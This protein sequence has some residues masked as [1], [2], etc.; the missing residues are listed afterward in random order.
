MT[1]L[2][3]LAHKALVLNPPDTQRVFDAIPTAKPVPYNGHTLVAVPYRLDETRVLRNMGLQIPSPIGYLYDWPHDPVAI[4]EVMP[5][6]KETSA[7]LTLHPR[8]YCLNSIGCG[9]TI[10]TG[11]AADFLLR[12]GVH[13]KILVVAPLSTLNDAWANAIFFHFGHLKCNVL[14][15]TA[16]KRRKL[17]L[18][19]ADIYVINFD[20]LETIVNKKVN[21]KGRVVDASLIRDDIGLVVLDEGSFLRNSNT[22]RYKVV[23]HILKPHMWCWDLTATPTPQWPTDAWAQCKLVTPHTVPDHFTSFKSKTMKQITQYKWEPLPNAMDIVYEAMRPAIRFTRDQVFADLEEP[24]YEQRS[25]ELTT[26]QKKHYQELMNELSTELATGGQVLAANEGVKIL[27]LIQAACGVMYD[28]QGQTHEVDCAPRI[29][30]VKEIIEQC[31]EKVIVFAPLEGVV[32]MLHREISKME[33]NGR[34]VTCEIVHG[35]TSKANRDRIYTSFQRTPDPHVIVAQPGCMSHGL[36][37][38]EASTII[39]YAPI[40]SNDIY[41]QANGRITRPGQKVVPMIVNIAATTLEKKMYERLKTKTALQ[42]LLLDMVAR[43]G[44]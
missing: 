27:K 8:A 22:D 33:R 39:W 28:R 20:G 30:V 23:K 44:E 43:G 36:T 42:G 21:S 2:V 18:E 7:F 10:S 29:N 24:V 13:K 14:Y 38:T 6:Q 26:A 15:G 41:T 11:W 25:I 17:F 35:A 5:L 34:H 32:Q 40:N 19:D 1:F 9:K 31:G 12:E 16:Q 3:S 37:L 4:P